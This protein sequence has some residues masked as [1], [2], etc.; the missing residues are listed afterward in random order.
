MSYKITIEK[1]T[2]EVRET[3]EYQNLHKKDSNNNDI[4]DYV[5]VTKP[6]TDRDTI[7]MQV[8]QKEIEVKP[9]IDAFNAAIKAY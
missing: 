7:Y 2:T 3:T 1:A 5:K 4:Y 9:L 8:T 6:V